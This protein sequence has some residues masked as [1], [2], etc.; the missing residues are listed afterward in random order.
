MRLV[1]D[2]GSLQAFAVQAISQPLAA[3]G[4]L[5]PLAAR[6]WRQSREYIHQL[7]IW[8][9]RTAASL[10]FFEELL[11]PH[12]LRKAKF[13]IRKIRRAAGL[14]RDLDVLILEIQNR[15]KRTGRNRG[16][17]EL[18][19]QRKKAQHSVD[20]VYRDFYQ[21]GRWKKFCRTILDSLARSSNFR[22]SL[23]P[24][25]LTGSAHSGRS[26]TPALQE[27]P[28]PF[29]GEKTAGEWGRERAR[30][31]I[32][33]F[34]QQ[35]RQNGTRPDSERLHQ[36]RLIAKRTR[37]S[38]ELVA[39][40][41]PKAQ[42]D[43]LFS[44]LASLQDMLGNYNDLVNAADWMQSDKPAAGKRNRKAWKKQQK[45]QRKKQRK[46]LKQNRKLIWD[47][48]PGQIQRICREFGR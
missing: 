2:D 10:Q 29:C 7:R 41:Y 8:T 16:L 36:F 11:P 32:Q 1:P 4:K 9:R 13:R 44:E 24:M 17:S 30:E 38:L 27:Q 43:Q 20:K 6:D 37:Y 48:M 31:I 42:I 19:R 46:K 18:E 28:T 3:V 25:P 5:L 22:G 39:D 47:R 34:L 12:V 15:K 40:F 35:A 14:A 33:D 23:T 26:A 45:R 21:K